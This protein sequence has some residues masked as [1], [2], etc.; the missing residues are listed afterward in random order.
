MILLY[1]AMRKVFWTGVRFSPPPPKVLSV[2]AFVTVDSD[3][4]VKS[5]DRSLL[6][7]NTFDGGVLGFDRA[8]SSGVDSTT[9][10]RRK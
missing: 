3:C 1:E 4:S 9:G 6:P 10:D 5:I 8:K 7:D 2:L